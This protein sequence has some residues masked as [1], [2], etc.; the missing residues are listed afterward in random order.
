[1]EGSLDIYAGLKITKAGRY[2][3]AARV[4]DA[5][6]RTFAYLSFNEELGTGMKEAK[7]HLFGKLVLDQKAKPPFRLRDVEGFLLKENT[8]PDRE[9]IPTL[10]GVVH[11][12]KMYQPSDF[13]DKEWESEEKDR[14]VKEFTKDVDEAQSHVE[15]GE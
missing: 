11:T 14:H 4:D 5:E 13:S 7:L 8:F 15:S 3:L 10:E 1:V 9:L 6:G 2:V 12:T